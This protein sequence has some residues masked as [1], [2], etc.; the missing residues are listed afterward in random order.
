MA[1][2]TTAVTLTGW[3]NVSIADAGRSIRRH[4][5]DAIDADLF[6]AGTYKPAEH[7][8]K[9]WNSLVGLQ[10]Y[11]RR[12]LTL[13]LT[14]EQLL[15]AVRNMA[16]WTTV[17]DAFKNVR[18]RRYRDLSIWAP[19]LGSRSASVLREFHDYQRV[20]ALLRQHEVRRGRN[21]SMVVFSRLEMDWLAP[22]PPLHLLR[23]GIVWVPWMPYPG[24]NDHHAVMSREL[25]DI[26]FSRWQLLLTG[27]VIKLMRLA[28]VVYDGPEVFLKKLLIA[29]RVPFGYFPLLGFLACCNQEA[30][31][32]SRLCHV[33]DGLGDMGMRESV[34]RSD[35]RRMAVSGRYPYQVATA[36]HLYRLLQATAS[37]CPGANIWQ[38]NLSVARIPALQMV[39]APDVD[40][41]CRTCCAQQPTGSRPTCSMPVLAHRSGEHDREHHTDTKTCL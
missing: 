1:A 41:G 4:L 27:R 24:L 18:H 30:C 3:L 34:G 36:V 25:A 5:V 23:A 15:A 28:Y 10:P 37:S 39:A 29:L 8:R 26:Y 22:H 16:E 20:L 11:T 2:R 7:K 12:N 21:Y 38:R 35:R 19:V 13:M 33:I 6:V 31:W 9:L 40:L 17:R 14:R 32:Q